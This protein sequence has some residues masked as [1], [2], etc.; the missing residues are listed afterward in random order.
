VTTTV[1]VVDYGVGNLYSV[2]RA[3]EASGCVACV[4]GDR[5]EIVS[6][7]RVILPG[8]GAF[9]NGMDGLR[10]GGLDQ[11]VREFAATGRPL[12]GICLGMQ[13]LAQCSF[14]FGEHEGLGLIEG[15][16]RS[17]PAEGALGE[18]H[19]I[20]FIGWAHL[21]ETR[22]DGFDGTPLRGL[23]DSDAVYLVHS[24][25]FEPENSRDLLAVYDYDGQSITAAVARDNIIGC[26]F[27]PEKSA[28]TGLKIISQFL[29]L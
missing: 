21:R 24:F 5:T 29:A 20:P 13:M 28:A 6:A 19:K 9:R 25:H 10:A 7:D 3:V 22:T 12:L 11:A 18:P 14:E 27:H 2:A 16:V 23:D 26:Q 8:V 4:T 17:I 1:H 15:T